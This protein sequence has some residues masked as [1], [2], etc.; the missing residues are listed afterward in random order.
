M[1]M[2]LVGILAL[3]SFSVHAGEFQNMRDKYQSAKAATAEKLFK[4][5]RYECKEVSANNYT[6]PFFRIFDKVDGKVGIYLPFTLAQLETYNIFFALEDSSIETLS[7]KL[8]QTAMGFR[9]DL[10]AI[11]ELED[12][13]IISEF[14]VYIRGVTNDK[15]SDLLPLANIEDAAYFRVL[16]YAICETIS[17]PKKIEKINDELKTVQSRLPLKRTEVESTL[18]DTLTTY[19]TR[20]NEFHS[21]L[22][23]KIADLS[24]AGFSQELINVSTQAKS[25]QIGLFKIANGAC[26]AVYCYGFETV[27][28]NDNDYLITTTNLGGYLFRSDEGFD[29]KI[30]FFMPF[31]NKTLGINALLLITYD[32]KNYI[33]KRQDG[34]FFIKNEPVKPVVEFIKLE[35]L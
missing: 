14:S 23:E 5:R 19:V 26:G 16:K 20:T 11:R 12:G 25:S 29:T 32:V 9:G 1:K 6:Q 33:L 27:T 24:R 7:W 3:G 4:E 22:S 2:L 35:N 8:H 17:L 31:T 18:L 10:L 30:V 15:Y 21:F 28:A 34:K 13:S